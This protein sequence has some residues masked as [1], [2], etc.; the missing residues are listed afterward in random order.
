MT[1]TMQLMIWRLY[2]EEGWTVQQIAVAKGVSRAHV[3]SAIDGHAR[4]RRRL[5]GLGTYSFPNPTSRATQTRPVATSGIAA[6]AASGPLT[7]KTSG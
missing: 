2:V 3:H 4:E 6:G 5:E 7:P 1:P